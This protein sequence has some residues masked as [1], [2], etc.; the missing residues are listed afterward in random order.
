[1]NETNS[2]DATSYNTAFPHIN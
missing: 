1:M 2:R